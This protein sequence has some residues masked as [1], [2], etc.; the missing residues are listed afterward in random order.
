MGVLVCLR[1]LHGVASS[2]GSRAKDELLAVMVTSQQRS[3][4]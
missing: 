4:A 1:D 2:H 3:E